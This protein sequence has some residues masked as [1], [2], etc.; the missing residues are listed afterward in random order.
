MFKLDEKEKSVI[1]YD[2]VF[3]KAIDMLNAN[4]AKT[5]KPIIMLS[6]GKQIYADATAAYKAA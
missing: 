3:A 4:S 2:A 6:K 5:G 1:Y